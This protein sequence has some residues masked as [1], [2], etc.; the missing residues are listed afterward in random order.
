LKLNNTLTKIK[1]DK[2]NILLSK[3]KIFKDK[4][5]K[6]IKTEFTEPS[7]IEGIYNIKVKNANGNEEILSEG[8]IDIKTGV[9]TVVKNMTSLNGTKT[10]YFYQSDKNGNRTSSYKITSKNGKILLNNNEKFTVI[11]DKKAISEKNCESYEMTYNQDKISIQHNGKTTEID[12]Y[13]FARGDISPLFKL[14]GDELLQM[15]NNVT[16]FGGN[17]G[18]FAAY[19]V[20]NKDVNTSDNNLSTLLH[21]LGHAK[22][23]RNKDM[24]ISG[25]E[26]F[27]KVFE[28]EKE[29]FTKAFSNA[30]RTQFEYFIRPCG[31]HAG[32]DGGKVECIAEANSLLNCCPDDKSTAMRK[33]LLQQY[34]PESIA[35]LSN[36]LNKFSDKPLSTSD[37]P[38]YGH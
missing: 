25:D 24:E 26:N 35:V 31:H 22:D 28:K 6:V 37:Q 21:E 3:E 15:K 4:A 23:Y 36:L 1:T 13:N 29:A 34:F 12:L 38:C 27:V 16:K 30:E 20:F 11:S 10:E 9:S 19:N 17:R 7:D 14:S 2:N 8:K 32:A 33:H 5:G 18:S